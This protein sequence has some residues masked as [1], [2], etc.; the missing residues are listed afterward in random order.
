MANATNVLEIGSEYLDAVVVCV[1]DKELFMCTPGRKEAG[2]ARL[3]EQGWTTF[4]EGSDPLESDSV[5]VRRVSVG[6][7]PTVD[8]RAGLEAWREYLALVRRNVLR[9]VELVPLLALRAAVPT[10]RWVLRHLFK[11]AR[12][13]GYDAMVRRVNHVEPRAVHRHALRSVELRRVSHDPTRPS[14]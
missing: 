13:E 12:V 7:T 9:I 4:S 1:G 11:R 6:W 10:R 8:A 5:L 14:G 3:G 2:L